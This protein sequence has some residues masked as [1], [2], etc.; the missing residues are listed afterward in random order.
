VPDAH[1]VAPVEDRW[2]RFGLLLVSV[3]ASVA[4]QG[5]VAPG[6]VQ[7]VAVSVL[8][9]CTLILAFGV[10]RPSR[11]MVWLSY[12][13]AAGGIV[14]AGLRELTGAVGDG[15]AQVISAV[16]VALGPPAVALGVIQGRRPRPQAG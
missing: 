5:A 10:A 3:I 13:V 6:G 15:E 16:L 14:A 9:G 7:R 4:V 12:I 8:L 1:A 11:A 2:P